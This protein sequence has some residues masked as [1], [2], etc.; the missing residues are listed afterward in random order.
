MS[1]PAWKARPEGPEYSATR[2]RL[3]DAAEAIVRREGAS[4]LR[5]ESVAD[6]AGLHRSSVYRYF[7]SKEALLTAVVVQATLRV[8]RRVIARIGEDAPPERFLAEGLAMA[9][10]AIANEPVHRSLLSPSGSEAMTR[11]G[12]RALAAGLRPL[13]EPLFVAAEGRGL[14]RDGVTIDDALWWLLVV[15]NGLFRSPDTVPPTTEL[16]RR[17]ELLLLPALLDTGRGVVAGEPG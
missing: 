17:L 12:G 14:L 3:V 4:A 11:V 2:R 7:D 16:T 13:V 9:L 15:A 6:A 1:V 5:L 8:A 10:A